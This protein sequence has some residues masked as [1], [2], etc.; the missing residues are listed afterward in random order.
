[1]PAIYANFPQTELTFY[2][3]SDVTPAL[4]KKLTKLGWADMW[5]RYSFDEELKMKD[6]G[7]SQFQYLDGEFGAS[8]PI[9][10]PAENGSFSVIYNAV[11]KSIKYIF[12]GKFLIYGDTDDESAAEYKNISCAYAGSI[13]INNDKGKAIKLPKD[14]YGMSLP[15]TGDVNITDSEIYY[16]IPLT[17]SII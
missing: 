2:L 15:I 9:T 16:K 4:E 12:E 10:E 7:N 11:E 6:L 5:L 3:T 14:E 1:M 13:R 8:I 17:T